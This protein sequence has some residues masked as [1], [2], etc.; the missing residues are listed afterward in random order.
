MNRINACVLLLGLLTSGTL[1]FT[2]AQAQTSAQTPSTPGE[3]DTNTLTEI[4]IT[5]DR[6]EDDVIAPNAT[7]EVLEPGRGAGPGRPPQPPPRRT[8]PFPRMSAP[9]TLRIS[10]P[11]TSDGVHAPT[12]IRLAWFPRGCRMVEYDCL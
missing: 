12:A 9:I 8:R 4:V 11:I 5:L 2:R 3:A 1:L 7:M 6:S 10:L